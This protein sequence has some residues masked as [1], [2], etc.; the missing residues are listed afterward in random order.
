MWVLEWAK[1]VTVECSIIFKRWETVV[2]MRKSCKSNSLLHERCLE[3]ICI[4]L[5]TSHH[6]TE[7]IIFLQWTVSPVTLLIASY[8]ILNTAMFLHPASLWDFTSQGTFII[9]EVI[10]NPLLTKTIK[11]HSMLLS[12]YSPTEV[13][14]RISPVYATTENFL[15][16]WLSVSTTMMVAASTKS[17]ATDTSIIRNINPVHKRPSKGAFRNDWNWY[18]NI[19]KNVFK[20]IFTFQIVAE[21]SAE[22]HGFLNPVVHI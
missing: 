18:L 7:V 15:V 16:F 14:H 11:I 10:V 4:M 2:V 8:F 9:W 6:V 5:C 22:I 12:T 19:K 21:L 1:E 13:T 20:L 17:F 3:T